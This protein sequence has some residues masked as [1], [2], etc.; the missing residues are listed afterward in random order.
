MSSYW[1]RL[2]SYTMDG[3]LDQI[4]EA[5]ISDETLYKTDDLHMREENCQTFIHK[6]N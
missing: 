2:R 6:M 4:V 3:A 1:Y 5:N